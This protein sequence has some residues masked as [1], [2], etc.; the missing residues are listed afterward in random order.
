MEVT[1]KIR[2]SPDGA[3]HHVETYTVDVPETATLLDALDAVKDKR[4]GTLAYRKSCRMAV[5][6]SCGM[7]M[8]G[9][10]RAG[11]QDG[12]EAARRARATCR[13]SRPMGNLPVIKDLV[14]DMEPFWAKIRAVKPFLQTEAASRQGAPR[15]GAGAAGEHR[16]GGALHHVRL[17]RLRVQLDGVGPRLPR[18]GGA[19]QGAAL[20]RRPARGRR[21]AA[22][23][24]Q[25]SQR[26][27]RHLGLH[28]LLLLQPAL[29]Q[30]RRPARCDRQA[31]RGDVP[32]RRAPSSGPR[33]T[34]SPD[35]HGRRARRCA[36]AGVRR[37]D[38]R[39]ASS[40]RPSSCPRRSARSP[41]CSTSRSRCGSRARARCRTRCSTH[42]AKNNDEVKR[43]WK[44]LEA[45]AREHE[46]LGTNHPSLIDSHD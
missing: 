4:D 45:Q 1:L 29:P 10:R 16:Q 15:R 2:R 13:R 34:C 6:G 11:L 32:A 8:D 43:L 7:R 18:A 42:K 17:L 23:A 5:C 41:P 21:R 28:A 19:R 22:R 46:G 9:A 37:L 25:G 39:A 44:L 20:R 38:A 14:V 36:R 12:H 33:R 24:A 3:S 31:R 35:R 27:A 40:T 26:R 30:G